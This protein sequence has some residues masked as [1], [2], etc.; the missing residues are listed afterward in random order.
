MFVFMFD[1]RYSVNRIDVHFSN[2]FDKDSNSG[3]GQYGVNIVLSFFIYNGIHLDI[4]IN[5]K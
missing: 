3:M 5:L 2:V 4:K 1:S